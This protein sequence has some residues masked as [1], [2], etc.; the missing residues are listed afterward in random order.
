MSAI[1]DVAVLQSSVT[2]GWDPTRW[3]F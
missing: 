3:P 2:L 1:Y